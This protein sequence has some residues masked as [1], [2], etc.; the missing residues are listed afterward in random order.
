MLV[1]AILA[2]STPSVAMPGRPVP[3]G[4]R[5]DGVPSVGALVWATGGPHFCSASVVHSPRRNL[6][7]TAAHCIV[8]TGA[9]IVFVPEYSPT[10]APYGRWLVSAAY[11]SPEWLL[12]QDPQ[13]DYAFLTVAPQLFGEAA[14]LEDVVGAN[15]LT[16]DAGFRRWAVVLGYPS[17]VD[18]RP[19]VCANRTYPYE[20][21]PAFDCDGYIAGTSGGPWLLHADPR[22]LT[23]DVF[24]VIGGLQ[25]GGCVPATSYTS[26]FG[27]D[28]ARLYQ[29]AAA[30]GPGD[31]VLPAGPDGC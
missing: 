28:I 7:L 11:V 27:E 29:R 2:L 18:A 16:V 5:F 24:G 22:T 17:D 13:A 20:G 9:G 12:R 3:T 4:V 6:V 31:L 26:Y 21:H 14:E 15:R 1:A 8:G 30:G 23:G 19:I 10:S 25:Q